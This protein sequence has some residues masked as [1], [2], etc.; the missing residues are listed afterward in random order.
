MNKEQLKEVEVLLDGLD[1]NS[2]TSILGKW[3]EISNI[4][5]KLDEL[6]D[7]L[8]VKVKAFMKERA[9]DKY[10]DK[11]TKINVSL[12]IEKRESI[13]KEKLKGILSEGQ[14][15]QIVQF[16]TFEKLMLSTPETRGRLKQYA[17]RTKI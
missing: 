3:S 12:V 11:D 9:W 17:N 1:E 14:Y 6:E 15:A 10:N 16:K 7:M 13:D 2:I 4:R 8:K 5:K